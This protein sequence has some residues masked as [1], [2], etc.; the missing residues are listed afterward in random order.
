MEEKIIMLKCKKI[1]SAILC[2]GMMTVL[3]GCAGIQTDDGGMVSETTSE[4][5]NSVLWKNMRMIM[6][7]MWIKSL[8]YG[9]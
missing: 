8:K 3:V 9:W 1:L 7:R 4:E 2:A 6:C 5:G